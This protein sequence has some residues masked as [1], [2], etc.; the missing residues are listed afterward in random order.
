MGAPVEE[1]IIVNRCTREQTYA[2]R[3]EHWTRT[4]FAGASAKLIRETCDHGI[5]P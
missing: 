4:L 1:T 5:D 2:Y 3:L